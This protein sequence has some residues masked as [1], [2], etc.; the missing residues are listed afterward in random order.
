MA[1]LLTHA[2]RVLFCHSERRDKSLIHPAHDPL[3]D[4]RRCFASLN[5][6]TGVADEGGPKK[7]KLT[8]A[9][10]T[11]QR[12]F[13]VRER[14]RKDGDDSG[15]L[16]QFFRH[17][18]VQRVSGSVMIIKIETAVLNRT[19]SRHAGF[20]HRA[21]VGPTMFDQVKHACA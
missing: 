2:N 1:P 17:D 11:W 14:I 5:M 20:F 19:E 12:L 8:F 16:S 7:D 4:N 13:H 6:T 10:L 21:N 18:F 15:I 3:K 9:T